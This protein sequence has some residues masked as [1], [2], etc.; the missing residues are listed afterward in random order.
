MHSNDVRCPRLRVHKV[1]VSR[2]HGSSVA[3]RDA[4]ESGRDAAPKFSLVWECSVGFLEESLVDVVEE[5][6]NLRAS[7]T[8]AARH[9]AGSSG[10]SAALNSL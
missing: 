10:S 2:D 1:A 8:I 7:G 4:R 9:P 3:S 6:L 5:T